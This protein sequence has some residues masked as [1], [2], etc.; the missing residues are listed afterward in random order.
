MKTYLECIPCF[1]QQALGAVRFITDDERVHEQLLRQVIIMISEMDL[2]VTPPA[3]GQKFHRL[4]REITGNNDPYEK[5]KKDSN[6]LALKLVPRLRSEIQ[7][8]LNPW[9]TAVRLAIAG[10]IIDF[11]KIQHLDEKLIYKALEDSAVSP[12]PASVINKLA[13]AVEQAE[14]ILYLGD[15]AGEIVFDRLLI[16]L[17]PR[18]KVTYGVRGKPTIN[19]VT[20]QD[21]QETGLTDIVEVIDNGSDAPGTILETCS[22]EFRRRFDKADLIISKGQGNYESL[23][24]SCKDIFFLFRV[25]CAVIARNSGWAVDSLVIQRQGLNII[26]NRRRV[27]YGY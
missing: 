27:K 3:M 1:I 18:A 2:S 19:D 21:A 4:I 13:N 16:E 14:D 25:K 6:Q 11:A 5:I 7:N 24:D 20:R 22:P 10:N 12:P 26:N 9:E 23:S 15:N 8:S 17:M